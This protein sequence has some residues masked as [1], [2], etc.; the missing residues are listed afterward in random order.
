MALLTAI[1]VSAE[2]VR[3]TD[4]ERGVGE[5]VV[6]LGSVG[7]R[8]G[9]FLELF[10]CGAMMLPTES[11]ENRSTLRSYSSMSPSCNERELGKGE[12]EC[13]SCLSGV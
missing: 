2:R 3:A 8:L 10:L 7:R 1:E 5:A 11:P 6:L 9:G 4:L 12:V 13:V